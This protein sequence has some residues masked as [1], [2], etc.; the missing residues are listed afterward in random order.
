MTFNTMV[1]MEMFKEISHATFAGRPAT[2]LPF[3]KRCSPARLYEIERVHQFQAK[4]R[5]NE[6]LLK[7]VDDHGRHA[8]LPRAC[9]RA[10]QPRDQP[11]E[12]P[13]FRLFPPARAQ[14]SR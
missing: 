10:C 5:G 12:V 8:C 11:E 6:A 2:K 13:F 9:V 3:S 14:A 1:L 7:L 4:V